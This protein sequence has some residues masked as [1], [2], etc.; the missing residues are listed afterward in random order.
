MKCIPGLKNDVQY[1]EDVPIDFRVML[2]CAFHRLEDVHELLCKCI[3]VVTCLKV[4]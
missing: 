3:V 2:S 4:D 1:S